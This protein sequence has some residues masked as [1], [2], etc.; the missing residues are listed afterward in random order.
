[1]IPKGL[2]IAVVMGVSAGAI[3]GVYLQNLGSQN[4]V[5][6]NGSSISIHVEK[7]DYNLGQSVQVT[8]TNSGTNELIFS[9]D[10]PG[11]RVRALDGTVFFSTS[12]DGLKLA[13]N[14]Q[15]VFVWK[16][17]KNDNSKIIEGRYVIDSFAHD[18][19]SQKVGDSTTINILQ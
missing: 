18:S 15:H 1:M 17:Q 8:I 3:T 9:N 7:Q 6:P 12:F 10:V 13:P 2:L 11:L 4:T 19:T 16:Q 14:Q 5:L